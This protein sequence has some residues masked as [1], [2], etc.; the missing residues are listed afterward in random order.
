MTL[1]ATSRRG[2][3][4]DAKKPVDVDYVYEATAGK[5]GNS[6]FKMIKD[7]AKGTELENTSV[8]SRWE[9]SGAGRSDAKLSGGNLP[10]GGATFSE[11]WDD[12]FASRYLTA[13]FDPNAGWGSAG[14]CAFKEADYSKVAP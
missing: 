9:Q 4:H 7:L 5:G 10:A 13:S 14:A 6:E 8:K 3:A 1:V 2:L 12:T 11:C